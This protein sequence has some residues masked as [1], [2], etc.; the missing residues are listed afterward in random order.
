MSDIRLKLRPRLPTSIM[1]RYARYTLGLEQWCTIP[2]S[3]NKRWHGVWASTYCHLHGPCQGPG[4]VIA[5]T[6]RPNSG[7][8]TMNNGVDVSSGEIYRLSRFS[9]VLTRSYILTHSLI[10]VGQLIGQTW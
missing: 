8:H 5:P 10:L 1:S 7:L 2:I 3:G 9:T 6:K 4:E